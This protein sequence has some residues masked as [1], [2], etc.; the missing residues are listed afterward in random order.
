MWTMFSK[1]QTPARTA[2]IFQEIIQKL[3]NDREWP[4]DTMVKIGQLFDGLSENDES[5][6][7]HYNFQDLCNANSKNEQ[8]IRGLCEQMFNRYI[9]K[10]EKAKVL[11]GFSI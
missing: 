9:I 2:E 1:P 6:E 4:L 10:F 3:K 7:L 11:I 5:S 8:K